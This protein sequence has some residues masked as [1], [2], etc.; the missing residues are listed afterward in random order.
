MT[1][2]AIA[3]SDTELLSLPAAEVRRRC[4]T[5]HEFG[6]FFMRYVALALC[7]RLVDSRLQLL[8]LFRD[9]PSTLTASAGEQP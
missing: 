9:S 1:A 7:Q 6:Y 5:D 4:E 3:Q 8:D 2:T